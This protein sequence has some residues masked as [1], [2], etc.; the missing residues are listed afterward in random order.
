MTSDVDF[1]HFLKSNLN[2]KCIEEVALELFDSHKM[3]GRQ[4]DWYIGNSFQLNDHINTI[5][6]KNL[7]V[8]SGNIPP[9]SVLNQPIP[10]ALVTAEETLRGTPP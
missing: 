4:A 5:F 2:K 10:P 1:W 7:S 9:H 3:G 6:I 8:K